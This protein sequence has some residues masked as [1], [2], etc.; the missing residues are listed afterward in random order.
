[1]MTIDRWAKQAAMRVI[2]FCDDD[3]DIDDDDDDDGEED[4]LHLETTQS[5][6]IAGQW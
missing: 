6:R 3:D 1:M 5:N 2:S 4:E